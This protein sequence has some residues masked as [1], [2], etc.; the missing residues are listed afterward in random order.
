[1]GWIAS[2]VTFV[3][4]LLN[5]RK[6]RVSWLLWVVG[7]CVWIAHAWGRDPAIVVLNVVF[8]FVNVYGFYSWRP[9]APA[10][11]EVHPEAPTLPG[12]EYAKLCYAV[13]ENCASFEA[14]AHGRHPVYP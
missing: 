6:V 5:A 9:N 7:N 1:M 12:E 13:A 2:A 14:A 8:V 3:G 10:S 11:P 4:L